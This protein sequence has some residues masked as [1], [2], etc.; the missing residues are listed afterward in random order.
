MA[1]SPPD[2]HKMDSRSAC[3]QGVLKVKIKGH[4]IR[5]LSWILGMSYS[6]ID[7]LVK[8][9][10]VVMITQKKMLFTHSLL[11][12]RQELGHLTYVTDNWF[13][14]YDVA[15]NNRPQFSC[16]RQHKCILRW[17]HDATLYKQAEIITTYKTNRVRLHLWKHKLPTLSCTKY[18]PTFAVAPRT[19]IMI[20]NVCCNNVTWTDQK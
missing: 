14:N 13:T 6:I 8:T 1:G 2:F 15:R 20:N 10:N 11:R 16:N 19:K 7:G 4:V 3:I 12:R 17:Q 18:M 9:H 5:T